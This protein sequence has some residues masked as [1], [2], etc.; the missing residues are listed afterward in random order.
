[1]MDLFH[2]RS[3]E[4]LKDAGLSTIAFCVVN[5]E[6]KGYPRKQAAHIAIRTIRRFLELY[7]N[8]INMVILAMDNTND[9]QIYQQVLPLYFPR[10][11]LEES[12][13]AAMLPEDTGICFPNTTCC[14]LIYFPFLSHLLVYV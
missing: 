12:K 9:M 14:S 6:R 4:V 8:G 11:P 3:L 5:T 1:M 13:V 2:R 10:H 7:G